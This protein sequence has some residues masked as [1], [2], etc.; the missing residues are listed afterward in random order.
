MDRD[1][2]AQRER[3]FVEELGIAY[4]EVGAPPMMGRILARLLVCD[5]PEQTSAELAEYLQA[6]RGAIS[7]I[8][9]QLILAGLIEKAPMPGERATYF[10]LKPHC[11]M[12]VMRVRTGIIT[13]LREVG[14]RGLQIFAADPPGRRERLEE[15]VDLYR[16]MEA[17]MPEL[18][19]GWLQERSERSS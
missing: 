4:A 5:P 8:T 18:Y 3:H 15:F 16:Y 14:E 10:R 11:W 19:E 1:E 12:E 9:R 13:L 6:S 17:R 2:R 7:T